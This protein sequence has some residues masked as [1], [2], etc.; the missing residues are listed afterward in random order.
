MVLSMK[1]LEIFWGQQLF[2]AGDLWIERVSK[3]TDLVSTRDHIVWDGQ[4]TLYCDVMTSG[5]KR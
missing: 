5:V 1:P 2:N 3:T 4:S